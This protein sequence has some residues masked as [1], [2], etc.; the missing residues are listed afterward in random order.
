MLSTSVS[1]LDRLRNPADA[2]AWTCFVR[3]YGPLLYAWARHTGL[4]E[5]DAAD[6]VQDVFTV[7]VEQLPTFRYDPGRSFRGWLR[8][9]LLNRWRA[10]QRK[11]AP[12]TVDDLKHV[13]DAA[14]PPGLDEAEERRQLLCRSLQRLQPE[15]A[16][17]TWD[18]FRRHVLLGQSPAEVAAQLQTTVNAVYIA[19]SRVLRRLR[20]EIAGL[21]S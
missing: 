14:E 11:R 10:L 12:V 13:P 8:I 21:L 18:I 15:F 3:L 16:P 7:L 19:R 1:L 20:Q 6:L 9:I 4:S 5:A 17:A 2:D